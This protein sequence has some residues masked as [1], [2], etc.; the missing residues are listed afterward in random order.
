MQSRRISYD[1]KGDILYVSFS[2]KPA[3]SSLT[4]VKDLILLRF[5]EEEKQAIGLTFL[6]FSCLLPSPDDEEVPR[7][8]LERLGDFPERVRSIVWDMI[9]HPPIS[10]YLHVTPGT[11][12]SDPLVS[13]IPQPALTGLLA[14]LAVMPPPTPFSSPQRQTSHP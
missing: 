9:T 5:N 11:T 14:D 6:A 10:H 12:Q 3:D 7:F 8:R 4:I 2:S 1:E 13:L